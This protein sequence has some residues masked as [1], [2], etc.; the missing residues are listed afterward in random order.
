VKSKGNNI[1]LSGCLVFCHHESWCVFEVD[2]IHRMQFSKYTLK[3]RLFT[4]AMEK[5][6]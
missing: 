4:L 1:L 6:P 2:C 5:L 3:S